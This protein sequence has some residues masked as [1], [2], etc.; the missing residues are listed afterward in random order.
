MRKGPVTC[1]H[2]HSTVSQSSNAGR[3][4]PLHVRESTRFN[5]PRSSIL[6]KYLT[7]YHIP[8]P[9]CRTLQPHRLI[10]FSSFFAIGGST[11]NSHIPVET[12]DAEYL[13]P[14]TETLRAH[15]SSSSLGV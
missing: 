4:K 2:K 11:G 8:S 7:A 5:P 13:S 9:Q 6:H 3:L 10:Q 12:R 14:T 15:L 1:H